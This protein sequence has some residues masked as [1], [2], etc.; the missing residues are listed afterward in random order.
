VQAVD[1]G[2]DLPSTTQLE[3][4]R[5]PW[6]CSSEWWMKLRPFTMSLISEYLDGKV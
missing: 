2:P 3:D 1:P 6:H 4:F 5:L